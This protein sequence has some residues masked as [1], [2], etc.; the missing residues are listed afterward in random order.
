[1]KRYLEMARNCYYHVGNQSQTVEGLSW[2]ISAAII[3]RGYIGGKHS[4]LAKV[5]TAA[6]VGLEAQEVEVETDISS[7]LPSMTIVGK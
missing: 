6:V 5:K 4:M 3:G 2:L 1:M 7:G